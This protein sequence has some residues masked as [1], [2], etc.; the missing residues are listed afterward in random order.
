MSA[1]SI[2]TR[3]TR[4][5]KLR[6]SGMS[7]TGDGIRADPNTCR[8]YGAWLH[9]LAGHDYKHGAPNGAFRGCA[10]PLARRIVAGNP[11]KAPEGQA[12]FVRRSGR[13]GW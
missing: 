1:M 7:G 12:V 2:A 13:L 11:C 10:A 9:A 3:A 6:L 4:S 8:S 5:G